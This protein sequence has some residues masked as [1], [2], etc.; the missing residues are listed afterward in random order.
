MD[1]L[2]ASYYNIDIVQRKSS[3]SYQIASGRFEFAKNSNTLP[4]AYKE[5]L[6]GARCK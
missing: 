5:L 6:E 3:I 1:M 2:T 4:R